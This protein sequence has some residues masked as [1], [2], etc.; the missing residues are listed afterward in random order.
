MTAEPDPLRTAGRF[1]LAVR[2]QGRLAWDEQRGHS[3]ST[4]RKNAW[5]VAGDIADI[6]A[7]LDSPE[8]GSPVQPNAITAVPVRRKHRRDDG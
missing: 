3:T 1:R 7:L 4:S 8:T 2:H 5:S 6:L